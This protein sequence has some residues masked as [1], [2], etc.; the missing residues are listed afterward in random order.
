MNIALATGL[1]VTI[2]I[3]LLIGLNIQNKK[4]KDIKSLIINK[5][6]ISY[7]V[8]KKNKYVFGMKSGF[9]LRTNQEPVELL[10]S[11]SEDFYLHSLK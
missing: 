1:Y 3:V 11:L 8:V 4:Y 5:K 10:E 2:M 6:D 9:E 7:I